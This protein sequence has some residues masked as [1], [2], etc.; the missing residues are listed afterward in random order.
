VR[1][2]VGDGVYGTVSGRQAVD[3]RSRAQGPRACQTGRGIGGPSGRAVGTGR[4]RRYSATPQ[5]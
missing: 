3:G 1:P 2:G 4:R 5:N